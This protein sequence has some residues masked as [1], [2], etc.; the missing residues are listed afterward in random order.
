MNRRD[1]KF[2]Y[3]YFLRHCRLFI[4]LYFSFL[5]CSAQHLQPLGRVSSISL[6]TWY[7]FVFQITFTCK[8][9]S[10]VSV[11]NERRVSLQLLA[12]VV[13]KIQHC[14]HRGTSS[15]FCDVTQYS[16]RW[17][18]LFISSLQS[19]ALHS[20]CSTFSLIL[21]LVQFRALLITY[22]ITNNGTYTISSFFVYFLSFP[23]I[24]YL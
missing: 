22:P 20:S 12:H 1:I 2:P 16:R 7:E 10:A 11:F 8:W 17:R 24:S 21:V 23:S 18:R 9:L 4:F 14:F 13:W 5:E 6:A 19:S 3:G 15:A